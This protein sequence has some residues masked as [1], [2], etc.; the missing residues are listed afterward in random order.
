MMGKSHLVTGLLAWGVV[1]QHTD[2]RVSLVSVV[3]AGV[4]SLLPD[5]DHVGSYLGRRLWFISY[6]LSPFVSHRGVTHSGLI[7]L[8]MIT[9]AY[10]FLPE[11]RT[12]ILANWVAAGITGYTAHIIGDAMTRSGVPLLWPLKYRL[13]LPPGIKTGSIGEGATVI[14]LFVLTSYL[15]MDEIFDALSA[16]YR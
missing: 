10:Y 14:G 1:T 7:V 3:L 4:A 5:I 13:R 12:S 11:P 16:V 15:Y 9:A 8:A 6:P 2:Y